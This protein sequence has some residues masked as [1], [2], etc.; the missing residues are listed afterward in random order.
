MRLWAASREVY[1]VP[2]SNTLSPARNWGAISFICEVLNA[3]SAMLFTPYYLIN[4][5]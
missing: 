2:D 4:H 1:T 5:N 3:Y